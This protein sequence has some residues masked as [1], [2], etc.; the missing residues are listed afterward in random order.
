MRVIGSN[1]TV[2]LLGRNLTKGVPLTFVFQD[3]LSFCLGL[4]S[5][6]SSVIII[7]LDN[8]TSCAKLLFHSKRKDKNKQKKKLP[9]LR[10]YKRIGIEPLPAWTIAPSSVARLPLDTKQKIHMTTYKQHTLL[11][12]EFVWY[13]NTNSFNKV[14]NIIYKHSKCV[15]LSTLLH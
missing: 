9:L 13:N 4:E 14:H 12:N 1:E 2:E 6:A 10:E 3:C 11:P 15:V 5:A 7:R 8:P